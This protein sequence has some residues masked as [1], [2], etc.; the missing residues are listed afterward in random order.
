MAK[1]IIATPLNSGSVTFALP[2]KQ[3]DLFSNE[4]APSF[5][6]AP[7]PP[8]STVKKSISRKDPI[9]ESPKFRLQSPLPVR[10]PHAPVNKDGE[11]WL[12]EPRMNATAKQMD[13][14]TTKKF[15]KE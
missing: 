15:K 2:V 10:S 9:G 13:H 3:H 14:S 4:V 7:D 11:S 1:T 5:R 12:Q 6:S 8:D